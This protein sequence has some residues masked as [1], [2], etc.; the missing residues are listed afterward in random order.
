MEKSLIDQE[1]A[2]QMK[3]ASEKDKM[4]QNFSADLWEYLA[5]SFNLKEKDW[6]QYSPLTL[7][8]IGDAVYDCIIR[9]ILV[10]RGNTQAAKLH[11]RASSLVKASAQAAIGQSLQEKLD[12]TESGIYRRGRNS[13]PGHTAKNATRDDYLEATGFEALVGYWFLTRQYQRMIDR[14]QE[15]LKENG[16]EI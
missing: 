11:H 3:E 1:M 5:D 12:E 4:G 13:K 2:C 15:G 7:A 6:S 9:T 10:K 14:I 16:Y 8:Y